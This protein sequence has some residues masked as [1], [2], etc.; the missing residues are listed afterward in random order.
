VIR[1]ADW[2]IDLWPEAGADGGYLVYTGK[3]SGLKKIEQS[4]TGQII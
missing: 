4:W 3:A 1:S 2:V